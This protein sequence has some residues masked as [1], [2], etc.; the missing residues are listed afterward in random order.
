MGGTRNAWL[1][2][3]TPTQSSGRILFV[4]D[5]Y[6]PT[7]LGALAELTYTDNW[8]AFG[9]ET[10]EQA[11]QRGFD[12]IDT[13]FEGGIMYRQSTGYNE[14]ANTTTQTSLADLAIPAGAMGAHGHAHLRISWGMENPGGASMAMSPIRVLFGGVVIYTLTTGAIAAGH[15]GNGWIDIRIANA[16]VN[17]AQKISG[18]SWFSSDSADSNNGNSS[19]NAQGAVYGSQSIDTTAEAA[20]SVDV[21]MSSANANN[22][23]HINFAELEVVYLP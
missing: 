15:I 5:T 14:L 9:D 17:G 3:N 10:P 19:P 1:T 2:P 18:T 13:L 22:K 23:A 21:K 4:P 8:E 6:W 7:V 11:A 20:I 12:I 16:G